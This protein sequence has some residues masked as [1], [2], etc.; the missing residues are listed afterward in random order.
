MH[1]L[2]CG[3][4]SD[5]LRLAIVARSAPAAIIS[6]YATTITA[7]ARLSDGYSGAVGMVTSR[8]HCAISRLLRPKSSGPKTIA[9]R[10]RSL[11]AIRSGRNSRSAARLAAIRTA[12]AGGADAK[13]AVSSADM[14]S[15]IN[16]R[17]LEYVV[18]MNRHRS[19]GRRIVIARCDQAQVGEAHVLE[20]ACG[21]PH[22]A[23]GLG[24]N[25]HEGEVIEYVH[26]SVIDR[27]E[28]GITEF[29]YAMGALA[30]SIGDRG[31]PAN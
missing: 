10:L 24:R 27:P 22:V 30:P 6:S 15:G 8:W 4:R 14:R 26:G 12:A 1:L 19:G 3:G 7:C 20:R 17:A 18:R 13:R 11:S 28:S 25:K 16:A 29:A 21:G 9:I 31:S 2:D 5:T 23:G